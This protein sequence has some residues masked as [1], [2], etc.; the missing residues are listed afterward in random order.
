MSILPPKHGL[1]KFKKGSKLLQKQNKHTVTDNQEFRDE[2]SD[3]SRTTSFTDIVTESF[4]EIEREIAKE[5]PEPGSDLV[6][7]FE[8]RLKEF[9]CDF[10]SSVDDNA[11]EDNELEQSGLLSMLQLNGIFNNE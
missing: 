10:N 1:H 7:Y 11:A 9:E 4:E 8:K 2:K 3:R 6:D 5:V